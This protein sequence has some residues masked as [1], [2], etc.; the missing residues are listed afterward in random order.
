MTQLFS[1]IYPFNPYDPTHMAQFP[2][3]NEWSKSAR[4]S[5][6]ERLDDVIAKS[7]AIT[8][9]LKQAQDTEKADVFLV[10][11]LQFLFDHNLHD[12]FLACHYTRFLYSKNERIEHL[13]TKAGLRTD[14]PYELNDEVAAVRPMAAYCNEAFWDEVI[15]RS[16]V[17][18]TL[19]ENNWPYEIAQGYLVIRDKAAA[20]YLKMAYC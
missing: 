12:A 11:D 18:A 5:L 8:L 1:P 7:G 15:E 14:G 10:G 6:T 3:F 20:S 4:L 17:I 19:E 2:E 16:Q 9:L 13:C